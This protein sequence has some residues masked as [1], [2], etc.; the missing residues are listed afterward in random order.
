MTSRG[1]QGAPVSARRNGRHDG[2][3]A[4]VLA[5]AAAAVLGGATLVLAKF[6]FAAPKDVL[7]QVQQERLVDGIDTGMA[8]AIEN[9]RKDAASCHAGT[10]DIDDVD[11]LDGPDIR[12]VVS[13]M[14]LG[15]DRYRLVS[16][17]YV[18][19]PG[20]PSSDRLSATPALQADITLLQVARDARAVRVDR[21]GLDTTVQPCRPGPGG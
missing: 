5:L 10:V 12:V 19:Q 17:G 4:V 21:Q 14:P 16:T 11:D 13:C 1:A 9:V 15:G 8:A 3:G 6:T 7:I 18:A 2:G 20:C